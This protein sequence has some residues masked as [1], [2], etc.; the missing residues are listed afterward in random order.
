[1]ALFRTKLDATVRCADSFNRFDME[2]V[3]HE[4]AVANNCEY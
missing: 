2:L 4:V 1:M 3:A